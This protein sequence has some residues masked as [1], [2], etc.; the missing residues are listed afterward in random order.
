MLRSIQKTLTDALGETL[1]F[2]T[3]A[4]KAASHMSG[5]RLGTDLEAVWDANI[6]ALYHV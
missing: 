4:K 1:S 2:D 3:E 5:K 6:K